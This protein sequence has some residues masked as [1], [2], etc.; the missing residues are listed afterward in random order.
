MPLCQT[1]T[2]VSVSGLTSNS[3]LEAFLDLERLKIDLVLT[4]ASEIKSVKANQISTTTVGSNKRF[5]ALYNMLHIVGLY[6]MA[7][8]THREPVPT[9][10]NPSGYSE[11]TTSENRDGTFNYV[12]ADDVTR[13]AHDKKRLYNIMFNAFH[14]STHY[15]CSDSF[16][17]RDGIAIYRRMHEHFYGHTEA[18][19]NRLR[20][21][22]QNF[23]GSTATY[24]KE[25]LVKF[26]TLMTEFEYV[27]ARSRTEQERLQFLHNAFIN[28]PRPNVKAYFMSCHSNM[29]TY[30]QTLE[31][32]VRY[33]EYALPEKPVK[34]APL[35]TTP[36]AC[37]KFLAGTCLLG[38]KCKHYH[39][40]VK[41]TATYVHG[42]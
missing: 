9:R 13:W 38:N 36:E 12:P 15:L 17:L 26:T 14:E 4:T 16:T 34:I 42:I 19:I 21:L 39:A 10:Q 35:S 23:K 8:G 18:D 25:D 2:E 37:R 32:S 3:A 5:K 28:D 20:R 24:F 31:R 11:P 6:P 29:L 30:R 41:P 22:L 27:Q 40:P 33:F 7:M 1:S